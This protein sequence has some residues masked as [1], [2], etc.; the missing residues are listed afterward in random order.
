MV[1]G[2]NMGFATQALGLSDAG[3]TALPFYIIMH[4]A[5]AL[6]PA[7]VLQKVILVSIFFLMGVGAHR[8]SPVREWPALYCGFLYMVNPFTYTR[9]VMGHW[10]ILGAY[11]VMPFAIKSFVSLLN[12]PGKETACRA[13]LLTFIVGIF[14]V[15]SIILLAL[16]YSL[17]STVVIFRTRDNP[18]H[19]FETAVAA[20]LALAVWI[21]LNLSWLIP[22]VFLG[23]SSQT[24]IIGTE[25]IKIFAPHATSSLG[26]PFDVATLWGFWRPGIISTH[27]LFPKFWWIFPTILMFFGTIGL[28][29]NIRVRDRGWIF[30]VFGT[31]FVVAFPLALGAGSPVTEPLFRWLF[32]TIPYFYSMRDSH[33]F[34]AILALCYAYLGA[35]G[36][37][38]LFT[39]IH[40]RVPLRRRVR[41]A[42]Q[43]ILVSIAATSIILAVW[44][45]FGTSGQ[46]RPLDFPDDWYEAEE[47]L[48]QDPE[49]FSI[50]V[51]PWHLYMDYSWIESG[52]RRVG[53]PAPKFFSKPVISG[54][55]AE[56][57]GLY[58][59][60]NRKLSEYIQFLLERSGE[61]NNFGELI[62]PFGAKYVIL[63]KEVDY[64]STYE[65][66][67]EQTDIQL[68]RDTPSLFLYRNTHSTSHIYSADG[69]VY[70][71]N[72]ETFLE[73]SKTQDVMENVYIIGAGTSSPPVVAG[74][75]LKAPRTSYIRYD[76]S[77]TGARWTIFNPG[78]TVTRNHWQYNGQETLDY[79]L[80]ISPVFASSISG[81]EIVQARFYRNILI[82][83]VISAAVLLAA[84]AVI[85]PAGW[86][87]RKLH[88]KLLGASDRR[89]D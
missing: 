22:Q 8:L 48:K 88:Q 34:V 14:S 16:I 60:S 49:D 37:A 18:R 70:V 58:S 26:I 74:E 29:T 3:A 38:F 73:L 67:L 59:D 19:L 81:G 46:I 87:P 10:L 9:L 71:S 85:V 69:T 5:L 35:G 7:W 47:L 53:N 31:L 62:A 45:I 84:I 11:A 39:T 52:Q 33:K 12:K 2:P 43:V 78:P 57:P 76:V 21:G 55:N 79:N 50:L 63:F 27:D 77:G 1:F 6:V 89:F 23:S 30:G 4:G 75:I 82:P 24:T 17:L 51:L 20:L 68:V 41:T 83:Y 64:E 44:P 80:G 66:L 61:I 32:E 25:H 40:Q 86:R 72:M 28:L 36:I 65:F 42:A 54:D 13:A 15:Q 56:L